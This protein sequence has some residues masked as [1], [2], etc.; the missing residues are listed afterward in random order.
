MFQDEPSQNIKLNVW[1]IQKWR[2]EYL[3][4][5]PRE[6]GMVNSTIIPFKYL[7]IPD[8]YLYNRYFTAVRLQSNL[9]HT[10]IDV[11]V[12]STNFSQIYLALLAFCTTL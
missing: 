8:T 5:D 11:S 12:T 4:W 10:C 2:D 1:M 6:Y 3:T 9:H 7:W